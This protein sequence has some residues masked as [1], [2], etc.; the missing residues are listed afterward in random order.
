MEH[1]NIIQALCRSALSNPSSAIIHQVERLRD[2]LKKD[3]NLKEAKSLS[4]LLSS[5]SKTTDMAPSRI[6]RS[7]VFE[8][9]ELTPQTLVPVDKESS[10]PLAEVIFKNNLP[11]EPPLFSENVSAA[12]N[13]VLSEWQNYDKLIEIDAQPARSCLIHGEPGTGKTHLAMWIAGQINMPVVLARLDGLM[14]S[15][16]GTSSR[17]ISNLFSFVSRYKCVLLLDEFDAIAK[18]RDDP[19]EVGEIKRVVNTLLQNLDVRSKIGFTIGITNHENLLDPAIWRRFDVQIEIPKPTPNVMVDLL[20]KF[21]TPLTFD[22]NQINF[23]AWAIENS[24]GADAESLIKWLKKSVVLN[25]DSNLVDH[26]RKFSILNSARINSIR[27]DL[28]SNTDDNLIA[29]LIEDKHF[30]F[31]QK[32]IASL[33]GIAPSTLS[34]QLSKTK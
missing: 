13:S 2:E 33:L 19:Q 11:T 6:Q 4:A 12:V 14:S 21:L 16:L 20:Q 10:A 28:L 22:D 1:F 26:I 31:K 32:D 30:S 8:G 5:V 27:R 17:N 3:G 29:A 23:L 9:E 25:E 7:F 34:K 15:F 18:L 24:S